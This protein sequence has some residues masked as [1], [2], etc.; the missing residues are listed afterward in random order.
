[1]DHD[2]VMEDLRAIIA[3]H[4]WAVRLVAPRVGEAGVPFA[5]TVGLT[6]QGLPEVI[7]LGLPSDVG[8]RFLNLVAT[9]LTNGRRFQAPTV[10]RDLTVGDQP[11]A[12]LRAADTSDLTA[13][14][15]LYGS[16]DALQLVWSDSTGRLPWEPGFGPGPEAQPLLGP[17][18]G[19]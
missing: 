19:A 14:A 9:E 12:F 4:G 6:A 10:V 11:V 5:Y 8:H 7:E 16:V 1:M 18:T 3:T 17:W 2:R 15:E 13:A